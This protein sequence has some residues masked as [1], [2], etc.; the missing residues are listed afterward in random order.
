MQDILETINYIYEL[1]LTAVQKLEAK[2]S[3]SSCGAND[4][5]LV[6]MALDEQ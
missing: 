5:C 2:N 3:C 6:G 1:Y 4:A